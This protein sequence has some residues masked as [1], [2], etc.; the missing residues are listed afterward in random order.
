MKKLHSLVTMLFLATGAFSQGL[1][2]EF[3]MSS[4]GS[5][6]ING[7]MKAYAQDGNYRTE[8]S[9]AMPQLQTEAIQIVSLSL[10]AAPGK[11][12]LLNEKQKTYSETDAANNNEY[13]DVP[14]ANYEVI[15][16]GKEAANRYTSTHVAVKVNGKQQEEMWTT[17]ELN[18][19]AEFSKI[20]TKYT[21]KSN[22]YK[23]L[24]AKGADG[25]P[26]RIKVNEN[27]QQIQMDL[28]KAERRNNPGN[29]FSLAGYTKTES[30]LKQLFEGEGMQQMMEKLQDMSP[31]EREEMLK[32]IQKQYGKHPH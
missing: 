32:Q 14:S 20:K 7:S 16:L 6:A 31:E 8:I 30:P 2:I 4:P 22:L 28:V 29:L 13:D 23:A 5:N 25:M 10:N 24:A 26:V 17:K 1:Y 11:T 18:G 15:V 9:M 19:F 27:G 21:G 3:K 12:Y